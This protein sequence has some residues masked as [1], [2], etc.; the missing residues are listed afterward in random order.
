VGKKNF[1]KRRTEVLNMRARIV[2]KGAT[3]G[4]GTEQ[5]VDREKG[6]EQG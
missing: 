2:M 5:G 6:I 1:E 3:I 4:V